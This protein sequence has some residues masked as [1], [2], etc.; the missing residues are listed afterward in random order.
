MHTYITCVY[1]YIFFRVFPTEL[2]QDVEYSSLSYIIGPCLPILDIVVYML[3]LNSWCIF[4]LTPAIPFGY[5]KFVFYAYK[6]ISV[7]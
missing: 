1:V 2:L 7:L 5:C 3:I 4:P 6:Y